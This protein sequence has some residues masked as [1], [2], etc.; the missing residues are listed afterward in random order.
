MTTTT[1]AARAMKMAWAM[2]RRGN[3]PFSR[4]RFALRLKDA[5]LLVR[6]E[7]RREALA[8]LPVVKVAPVTIEE[9]S[10]NL[11]TEFAKWGTN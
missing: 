3:L 10:A 4:K 9:R 2:T 7:I 1:P 6:E 8:L 11:A 5:W